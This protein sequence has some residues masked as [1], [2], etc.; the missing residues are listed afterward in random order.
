M[1][2]TLHDSIPEARRPEIEAVVKKHA[3]NCSIVWMP[4]RFP[5][6][7]MLVEPESKFEPDPDGSTFFESPHSDD[8]TLAA[9][10]KTLE[11]KIK[12]CLS[13]GSRP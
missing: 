6:F 1:K 7:V 10:T 12:V 2:I 9:M 8:E 5:R 11:E 3:G 13:T 4:S